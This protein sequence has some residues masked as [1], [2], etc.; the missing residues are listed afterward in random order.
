MTTLDNLILYYGDADLQIAADLAQYLKCPIVKSCFA[1][2]ELIASAKNVYQVGGSNTNS[3]V[4]ILS[5][6]DRFDTIKAVLHA[7]G[8]I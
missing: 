3:N 7:L 5:G 4:K 6:Q 2:D 1:K 8:K